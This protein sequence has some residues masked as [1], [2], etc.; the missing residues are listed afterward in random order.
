MSLYL[1]QFVRDTNLL[2]FRR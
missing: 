1:F 2:E